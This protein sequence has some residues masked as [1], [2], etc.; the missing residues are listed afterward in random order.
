M[1]TEVNPATGFVELKGF[2]KEYK[3]NVAACSDIDFYAEQGCVTGLLG[4]NGAGKSTMLKAM[5]GVHYATRGSVTVCGFTDAVQIRQVTGFVPEYPELDASLS[6]KEL[7]YLSASMYNVEKKVQK[8]V[9]ESAVESCSLNE[10]FTNK[11]STLSKGFRQRVS[12][13]K[14]LSCNPKVLVLDEFSGGLDPE[15]IVKIKKML[16][17]LSKKKTVILSTHHI[18]EAE[19]LCQRIYVINHGSVAACGTKEEIIAKANVSNLEKAY[20]KLAGE[21]A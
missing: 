2:C 18:E 17:N 6:V 13:A 12:L 14:A 21:G 15:Q 10:V 19:S 11:I 7:L 20:L 8:E 4:P 9:V 1:K 16:M 5:C 3:K